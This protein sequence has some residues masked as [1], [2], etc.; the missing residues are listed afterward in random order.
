MCARATT[1][2]G[3]RGLTQE[4]PI[5]SHSRVR[6]F[7]S[8]SDKEE[9]YASTL[10]GMELKCRSPLMRRGGPDGIEVPAALEADPVEVVRCL[11][12]PGVTE[13]MSVRFSCR[14]F[15]GGSF[16]DTTVA[17]V[18]ILAVVALSVVL[19]WELG[20]SKSSMYSASLRRS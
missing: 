2:V 3:V 11:F 6:S 20:D 12:V 14:F 5:V 18:I 13:N 19:V 9:R 15:A 7:F 8:S 4:G 16:A 10:K 17:V 1:T